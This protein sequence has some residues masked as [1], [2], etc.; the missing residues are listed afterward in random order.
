[1]GVIIIVVEDALNYINSF[2]PFELAE[3]FDNVGLLIG[4]RKRC[5]INSVPPSNNI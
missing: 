4:K 1:M 2:A 5:S 3:D